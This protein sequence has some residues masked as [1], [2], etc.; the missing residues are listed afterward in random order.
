MTPPARRTTARC[1]PAAGDAALVGAACRAKGVE[2]GQAVGVHLRG[3]GDPCVAGRP[4]R[5]GGEALD[6][7]HGE[8]AHASAGV[9]LAGD[10]RLCL[11]RGAAA[12]VAL[13]AQ[14]KVTASTRT[15]SPSGPHQHS[16]TNPP[17]GFS[18]P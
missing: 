4:H 1:D 9:A 5:G 18:K 17:S 13:A 3:R 16:I 15:M 7:L 12:L 11:V 14:V 10:D 2:G 6:H 8:L